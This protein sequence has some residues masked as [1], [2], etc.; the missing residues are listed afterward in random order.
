MHT[1]FVYICVS[2]HFAMDNLLPTLKPPEAQYVITASFSTKSADLLHVVTKN[3]KLAA[4][5]DGAVLSN[6]MILKAF[7]LT[8]ILDCS[9]SY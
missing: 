2:A 9:S 1:L 7:L 3:R 4:L 6:L 8:N 5:H